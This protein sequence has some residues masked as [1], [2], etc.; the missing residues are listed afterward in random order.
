MSLLNK[1]VIEPVSTCELEADGVAA[2]ILNSNDIA[3]GSDGAGMNPGLEAIWEDERLRR[4]ILGIE[5]PLTA[6]DS[7]PR[8]R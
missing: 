6:P 7:P 2:D 8:T 5:E 3:E 4:E 1:Q